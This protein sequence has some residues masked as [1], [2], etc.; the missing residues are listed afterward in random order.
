MLP[1]WSSRTDSALV[2]VN[3][4]I[5]MA[6]LIKCGVSEAQAPIAEEVPVMF[7]DFASEQ[8]G[9]G[10]A[11][12][13]SSRLKLLFGQYSANSSESTKYTIACGDL[14]GVYRLDMHLY[15]YRYNSEQLSSITKNV[16]AVT[17]VM[18]SVDTRKIDDNTLRI[19]IQKCYAACDTY[20]REA[21]YSQIKK[22]M[23]SDNAQPSLHVM[24][25]SLQLGAAQFNG[26]LPLLNANPSPGTRQPAV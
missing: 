23:A 25:R 10:M 14:E 7:S 22:K 21:I 1:R 3:E 26:R 5:D 24:H 2:P 16:L 19:I 6:T 18:S 12:V 8:V 15:S 11:K 9:Q 13:L 17:V 20:E 4:V